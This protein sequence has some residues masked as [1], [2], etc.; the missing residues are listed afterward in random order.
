MDVLKM[1][2]IG[3]IPW[4]DT[5]LHIRPMLSRIMRQPE[6]P[7]MSFQFARMGERAA[8]AGKP[9][10]KSAVSK[11]DLLTKFME[12]QASDPT[13]PPWLVS[14]SSFRRHALVLILEIGLLLHG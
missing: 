4:M 12:I 1:V 11:P 10:D 7:I 3:Q 2:Q 5:R 13:L 6:D 14:N 8:M 9:H